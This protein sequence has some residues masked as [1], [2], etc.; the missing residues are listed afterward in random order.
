MKVRIILL[1]VIVCSIINCRDRAAKCCEYIDTYMLPNRMYVERYRTFCGGVFGEMIDCYITDS[2]SFRQ[3][4]GS[5]NQHESLYTK[6]DVDKII[7]Y[8]SQSRV[9]SDTLERKTILKTDL[10]KYPYADT[11]CVKKTP[12]FGKNTI[13]CDDY[14]PASSYRVTNG[15]LR[16]VQ[17]KC[18]NDYFNAV[19]YTD[20][21]SFCIFLGVYTPESSENNYSVKENNMGG[22]DFYN[23]TDR[24][25]T[26]TISTENFLLDDLKKGKLIQV[27]K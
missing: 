3:K 18:D 4:V 25:V 11:S 23:I 2:I 6:L 21:K 5:Y 9:I 10:G 16:Q 7:A 15:L 19:F 17:Y 13:K 1:L 12:L 8:R 20:S 26:D 14:V 27:C 22:L 24:R